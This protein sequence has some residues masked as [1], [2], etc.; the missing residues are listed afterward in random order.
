LRLEAQLD[1][2]I[3]GKGDPEDIESRLRDFE[4]T[5]DET[6]YREIKLHI[7]EN[8]EKCENPEVPS[9]QQNVKLPSLIKS[10][11]LC[12]QTPQIEQAYRDT[13]KRLNIS[14]IKEPSAEQ[15]TVDNGRSELAVDTA[16]RV[17]TLFRGSS[18]VASVHITFEMF[19]T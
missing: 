18:R 17:T 7:A 1:I 10:S 6:V 4:D 16:F 14:W 3:K 9:P 13:E 15:R 12:K 8:V 19:G 2:P 5:E 11:T